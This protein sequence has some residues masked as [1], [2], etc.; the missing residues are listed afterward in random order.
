MATKSQTWS[1]FIFI[2]VLAVQVCIGEKS[3][4]IWSSAGDV[5]QRGSSFEVYCTFNCKCKGCMGSMEI[6]P[7]TLQ[8]PQL[9]NS[10]TLYVNVVNITK[11]RT[12][13]CPC[14][15]RALERCGVDIYAGYPPVPPKN[16]SCIYKV[17]DGENG[18]V[19]CSW[20]R[21]RDTY[22][23]THL[24][25][26]VKSGSHTDEPRSFRVPSKGSD[27]Y[28]VSFNVSNSVKEISVWVKAHNKLGSMES[29]TFNYTLSDIA[30]PPP[31]VLGQ[32]KCSSRGCTIRV[33]QSVRT[34]HLELQY[35]LDRPTWKPYPDLGVQ[36]GLVQVQSISS[37]EPYRKYHFRAR[38][39]FSTGY[40]SQWSTHISCWTQEEAPAKELDVW[41]A[42][43]TS[44]LNSIR[45]YWKERNDSMARVK[46]LNYTLRIFNPDTKSVSFRNISAH[47]RSYL[48]SSC[49]NCEVT[50]WARNSKGWSPPAK[51]SPCHITAKPPEGVHAMTSSNTVSIYWRK[52]ETAFLP[53]GYV[54]EW[55]PEGHKLD[56]LQWVRVGGSENHV[57]ITDMK[58]FECYEGAVYV[59]GNDSSVGG[60]QF[61]GVNTVESGPTGGPSAQEKVQGNEVTVTWME[62][63]RSQRGGCISNYTIYV[64]NYDSQFRHRYPVSPQK[65]MHVIHNLRPATYMLWMTAWTAKGE[66]PAGQSIKF[67]IQEESQAYLPWVCTVVFLLMFLLCLGRI[68]AVR[69]RFA[70]FFHCLVLEVVPDPANS[71]WARECVK[72]KGRTDPQPES[73]S[74]TETDEEDEPI[75][76][77]VEELPEQRSLTSIP[78]VAATDVT[79]CL[80][81]IS[82]RPQTPTVHQTSYI[83]SLSHDSDNSD[84]T[85]TSLDTTFDY[86]SSHEP[87]NGMEDDE[88]QEE[89]FVGVLG[90]IPSHNVFMNMPGKLEFP[91]KLTLD[92][93][94]IDCSDFFQE[95]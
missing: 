48:V 20:N 17:L 38:A 65:R 41:F 37:L 77:D 44:E 88:D 4:T 80:L 66:G 32:T 5:V 95:S 10:T 57:I 19:F 45:V 12:F 39:K 31:P 1:T 92:A 25:L 14:S 90:F 87:D 15:S 22:F 51:L 50:V 70:V 69:Q 83:K 81:Q 7:P 26:W 78:A 30:L 82:M 56:E 16:I 67:F 84:Q 11:N 18:D 79:S 28:S 29:T 43:S 49:I 74:S 61:V 54:V 23:W 85:Q 94:K 71:K 3:C 75:I 35:R 6:H 76:V 46:I 62:L 8:L 68:S 73:S 33:Q 53:A 86:I 93:V 21:G 59:L 55:H 63:P 89:E 91:G 47:E 27:S 24:R 34:Q 13:S 72:E 58:P 60:A 40:W 9:F 64:E 2:T 52:P 36:M 42:A